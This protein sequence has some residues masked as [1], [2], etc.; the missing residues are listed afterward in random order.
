MVDAPDSK[1]GS[2]WS[3]GSSPSWGT[4]N[5]K[6]KKMKMLP[7]YI[8]DLIRDDASLHDGDTWPLGNKTYAIYNKFDNLIQIE[9]ENEILAKISIRKLKSRKRT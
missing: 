5:K 6:V 3:E 2:L 9:K 8:A 4:L 7:D 1:L